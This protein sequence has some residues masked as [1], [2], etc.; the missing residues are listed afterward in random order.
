ME[1]QGT[2][3]LEMVLEVWK[4]ELKAILNIYLLKQMKFFRIYLSSIKTITFQRGKVE[5][6]LQFGFGQWMDK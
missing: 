5:V 2:E 3:Y 4:A 6:A 1:S